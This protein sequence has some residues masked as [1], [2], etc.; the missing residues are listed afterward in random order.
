ML[1]SDDHLA[2]HYSAVADDGSQGDK[3]RSAAMLF[4]M[5]ETSLNEKEDHGSARGQAEE[6]LATFKKIGDKMGEADSLRLLVNT[7]RVELR[8][9]DS[10][11][12]TNGM[13]HSQVAKARDRILTEAKK[14]AE[15]GLAAFRKSGDKRG[16]ALMLLTVA[17]IG[18]EAGAPTQESEKAIQSARDAFE[19]F[20]SID[21]KSMEAMSKLSL[22]NAYMQASQ[23]E[24]A[25]AAAEY[26]VKAFRAIAK[27]SDGKRYL[28]DALQAKAVTSDRIGKDGLQFAE[29]AREI[30]SD[31]GPRKLEALQN[32]HIAEALNWR[33][34]F[35]EARPYAKK[36]TKLFEEL[37]Y[38]KGYQANA[39]AALVE[40]QKG[41]GQ[42]REALETCKQGYQLAKKKNDVRSEV[43][44]LGMLFK[45][46]MEMQDGD[47]AEA[48]EAAEEGLR[49]ATRV[50]NKKWEANFHYNLS[51]VLLRQ[52]N[53]ERGVEA[54]ETARNIFEDL[55]EEQDQATVLRTI[56]EACRDNSEFPKALE[57]S[58]MMQKIS[59]RL[60]LPSRESSDLIVKA[61]IQFRQGQEIGDYSMKQAALDSADE[62]KD[63]AESVGDSHQVGV[64]LD[65]RAKL[66]LFM[67]DPGHEEMLTQRCKA[68]DDLMEAA[69]SF[70]EARDP[71]SQISCLEILAE[72]LMHDSPEQ[73]SQVAKDAL[74]AAHVMQNHTKEVEMLVLLS[75]A[76]TEWFL[77]CATPG[78]KG[79]SR[80]ATWKH[81]HIEAMNPASAAVA[82][83]RKMRRKD[84]MALSLE[85]I[86]R[87]HLISKRGQ[88]A[89]T[90]IQEAL[91][92]YQQLK[93]LSGEANAMLLLAQAEFLGDNVSD[94]TKHAERALSLFEALDD[95][96]GKRGAKGVIDFIETP[97][98][99]EPLALHL[100]TAAT[101]STPEVAMEQTRHD[102]FSIDFVKRS[103]AK[104]V[105]EC[106]GCDERD[107]NEDSPL[108]DLGL[109]SLAAGVFTNLLQKEFG[110][111]KLPASLVFDYPDMRSMAEFLVDESGQVN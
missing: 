38:G 26:A 72:M 44:C 56:A 97:V 96:H 86:T 98:Q 25:Y 67:H 52:G 61:G 50:K 45:T 30:Y 70:C 110:A 49:Q 46:C 13:E 66:R 31:V 84:L 65:F 100:A 21:E 48:L 12:D 24:H 16:E 34:R 92:Y 79:Q 5:A 102:G 88:E 28:A 20:Q 103:I 93:D 107:V 83:S 43:L 106:S 54:A 69:Q 57:A 81:R 87:V 2:E 51:Q 109:D 111:V 4:S 91:L 27:D 99:G 35:R 33:S 9:L 47:L 37:D 53:H 105:V 73:V 95:E 41:V 90:C 76:H 14:I 82:M 75:R 29:E 94:A 7:R 19:L 71:S 22:V 80:S 10:E 68:V 62:A 89:Q 101:A 32:L 59:Q 77:K 108:M 3:R 1:M 8:A 36:A 104:Y 18:I 55:G 63:K 60:N 85:Q 74:N 11:K 17:D 64:A 42:S 23:V 40:A 58:N 6:A 78:K 39:R 15:E